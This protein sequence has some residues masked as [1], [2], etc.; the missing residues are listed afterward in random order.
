MLRLRRGLSSY[1]CCVQFYFNVGSINVLISSFDFYVH[2][3]K[4]ISDKI[5]LHT[6]NLKKDKRCISNRFVQQMWRKFILKYISLFHLWHI[7]LHRACGGRYVLLVKFLSFHA[8]YWLSLP[9]SQQRCFTTLFFNL[10]LR[11][12]IFSIVFRS[13]NEWKFQITWENIG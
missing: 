3:E 6:S 12:R 13:T 2:C 7:Q 10:S 11:V 9:P 8:W 5:N 1:H 4:W